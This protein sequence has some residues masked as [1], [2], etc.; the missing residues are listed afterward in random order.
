MSVPGQVPPEFHRRFIHIFIHG[1]LTDGLEVD[2][3]RLSVSSSQG[4]RSIDARLGRA[5]RKPLQSLEM[6]DF[7]YR[8]RCGWKGHWA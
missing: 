8:P 6:R 5:L 2:L 1:T 7:W 4:P 3:T